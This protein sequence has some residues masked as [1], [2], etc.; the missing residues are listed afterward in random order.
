MRAARSRLHESGID[1]DV[2]EWRLL[3]VGLLKTFF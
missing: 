3:I 2:F 1:E